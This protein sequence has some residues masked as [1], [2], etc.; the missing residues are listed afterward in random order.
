[1]LSMKMADTF[2]VLLCVVVIINVHVSCQLDD[3]AN[4]VKCSTLD[5]ELTV[6]GANN[7]HDCGKYLSLE[8]TCRDV[9][10]AQEMENKFKNLRDLHY[11]EKCGCP[12]ASMNI[13]LGCACLLIALV[14][15]TAIDSMHKF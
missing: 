10:D 11:K 7:E 8:K 9:V 12:Q 1:M 6:K 4:G 15:N 13:A 5:A 2:C 3:L 14:Y